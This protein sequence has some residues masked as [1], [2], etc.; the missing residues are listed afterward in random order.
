MVS[1]HR[2]HHR[3]YTG[4]MYLGID[5]GGTKTLVATLNRRGEISESIKFPTPPKYSDFVVELTSNVAKLTTQEWLAGA[6]AAPGVMDRK[7]GTFLA[8]GN[9][10][11]H[12][13]PLLKDVEKITKCPMLLENDAKLAGLSEALL[14]KKQYKKVLYITISTGIGTGL[15]VDGKIETNLANMESGDIM[16]QHGNKLVAWEKVASGKAVFEKYGKRAADINDQK[17][18]HAIVKTWTAGFL[19]LI[20]ITQPEAIVIGGSVGSYV[21][22]YHDLLV[23]ELEKYATPVAP[24]PPIL[25]A[26]RPEEAVVYG[27]YELARS[28]YA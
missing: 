19:D 25:Q 3:C 21:P 28:V 2:K 11:W 1:T 5:V 15:I 20:A 27:C 10:K 7:K 6:I 8:G 12:N 22:K 14:L 9:L 17:T 26:Q 18:W 16:V 4:S 24:V 23:A 13:S